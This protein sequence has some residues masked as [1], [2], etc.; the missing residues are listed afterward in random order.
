[1]IIWRGW[2]AIPIV[3]AALCVGLGGLM[4]SF[5]KGL[6]GV[7]A[8]L[9]LIGGGVGTWYLGQWFN[10]IKPVEQYDQWFARRRDE[11]AQMVRG[12]AYA[13]VPDP[14]RPGQLADPWAVGEYVLQQEGAKVKSALTDRHSLFFIPMQYIGFAMGAAGLLTIVTS[15]LRH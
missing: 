15:L 9:A 3:I 5:N 6:F 7:F 14:Q 11:V 10:R 8:G 4:S 2:G 12:G 1:M 13:N